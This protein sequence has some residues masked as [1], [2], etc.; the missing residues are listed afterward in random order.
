MLGDIQDLSVI[1]VE[2][3][4][5]LKLYFMKK[6][7]LAALVFSSVAAKAQTAGMTIQQQIDWLQRARRYL[8]VRFT[9]VLRS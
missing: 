6:L 3:E 5:K 8:S 9:K 7:V 4:Q 1:R 2:K